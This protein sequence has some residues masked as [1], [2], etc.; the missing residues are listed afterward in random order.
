MAR[1]G[2]KEISVLS[3]R[4]TRGGLLWLS[5]RAPERAN[6]RSLNHSSPWIFATSATLGARLWLSFRAP[7]RADRRSLNH[8]SPWISA[9]SVLSYGATGAACELERPE[10]SQ[11]V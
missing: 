4:S 10:R 7:K 1:L 9:I 2:E 11:R 5:F 6:R 8:C 3:R